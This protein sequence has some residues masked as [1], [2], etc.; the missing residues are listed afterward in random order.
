MGG[1]PP[2]G[3]LGKDDAK[4]QRKGNDVVGKV[5]PEGLTGCVKGSRVRR[6]LRFDRHPKI[7]ERHSGSEASRN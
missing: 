1:P 5:G 6:F 4:G 7:S 2:A 3:L